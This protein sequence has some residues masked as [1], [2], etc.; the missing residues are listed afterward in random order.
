MASEALQAFP[1]LA[2]VGVFLVPWFARSHAA[3]DLYVTL[4]SVTF[5]VL[6][7]LCSDQ[8]NV[9]GSLCQKGVS[10]VRVG[11]LVT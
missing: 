3:R 2:G 5:F 9:V 11:P 6:V 8:N 10:Q 4:N 1:L 7:S